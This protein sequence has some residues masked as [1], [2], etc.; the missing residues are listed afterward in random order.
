MLKKTHRN[1]VNKNL[2]IKKIK[3]VRTLLTGK[4]KRN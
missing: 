3:Y 1:Q 4:I 2:L